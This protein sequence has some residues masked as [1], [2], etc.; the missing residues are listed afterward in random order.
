MSTANVGRYSERKKM[1]WYLIFWSCIFLEIVNLLPHISH[2]PGTWLVTLWIIYGSWLVT[3]WIIYGSYI[4][5]FSF[6]LFPHSSHRAMASDKIL[7]LLISFPSG[8]QSV[9]PYKVENQN[10]VS[11]SSFPTTLLRGQVSG[12]DG[13][14]PWSGKKP[15]LALCTTQSWVFT[16][17]FWS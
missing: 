1:L 17:L 5:S 3:L 12:I 8:P 13:C 11:H 10:W 4:Y 6:K 2:F 9:A 7:S 15:E 14:M 16:E